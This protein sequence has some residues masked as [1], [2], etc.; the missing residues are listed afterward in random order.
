MDGD[1]EPEKQVDERHLTRAK[2]YA[3]RGTAMV[4]QQ[5]ST[6]RRRRLREIEQW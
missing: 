5:S 4:M 2:V 1:Y 3:G 6:E